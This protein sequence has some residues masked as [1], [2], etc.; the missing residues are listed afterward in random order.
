MAIE[1]E[2]EYIPG[3][4]PVFW[5]G[6]CKVLPGDYRLKQ[7]F[8]E[9]TLLVKGTP[10]FVDFDKMECAVIKLARVMAGGTGTKPRVVKGSLLQKGDTVMKLGDGTKSV[11]VSSI[12]TSNNDYDELT[13]SAALTGIAEGDDIQESSEYHAAGADPVADPEVEAAPL[14]EMNTV[15]SDSYTYQKLGFQTVAAG[16]EVIIL[17]E[18]AYPIPASWLE[19]GMSLKNNHSIKYVKQ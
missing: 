11:T 6:E 13:L 10:L 9:G 8:T 19:G 18:V 3:N 4:F 12:D 14:Y 5:R 7:E 16:Y 17:K 1:F 2:R 15:I